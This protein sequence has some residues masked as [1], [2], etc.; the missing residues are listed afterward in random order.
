[1]GI[2]EAYRW[3]L[4]EAV[5]DYIHK[6]YPVLLKDKKKILLKMGPWNKEFTS[7]SAITS[8]EYINSATY[9]AHREGIG[10]R[11]DPERHVPTILAAIREYERDADE[12]DRKLTLP[13]YVSL[14]ATAEFVTANYKMPEF[15]EDAFEHGQRA[16]ELLTYYKGLIE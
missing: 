1:M 3:P 15:Y 14:L 9:L 12:K 6:N 7:M 16:M 5:E 11:E 2:E 13:L 4:G 8:I 10:D